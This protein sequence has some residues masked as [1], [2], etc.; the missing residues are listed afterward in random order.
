M[1]LPPEG[2]AEAYRLHGRRMLAAQVYSGRRRQQAHCIKHPLT[3]AKGH[4]CRTSL[5]PSVRFLS[6]SCSTLNS[7]PLAIAAPQQGA[8]LH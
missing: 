5:H 3:A 1:A 7:D 6:S 4:V 2:R 8:S